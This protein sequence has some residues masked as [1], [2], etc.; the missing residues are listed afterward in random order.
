[1]VGVVG[2]PIF[3]P[4]ENLTR[5]VIRK[6]H[7]KFQPFSSKRLEII[8]C[9][10]LETDRRHDRRHPPLKNCSS[11]RNYSIPSWTKKNCGQ[12]KTGSSIA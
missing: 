4:E 12:Q 5:Q 2:G 7:T 11:L 6:H 1:M 10:K 8:P 9:L 3:I